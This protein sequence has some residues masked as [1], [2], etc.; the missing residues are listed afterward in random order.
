MRSLIR[1]F[2]FVPLAG[3]TFC[4]VGAELFNLPAVGIPPQTARAVLSV[5]PPVLLDPLLTIQ[6]IVISELAALVLGQLAA[7]FGTVLAVA[8]LW[9]AEDSSWLMQ[10]PS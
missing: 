6:S 3:L 5:V 1:Y 8:F 9:T 4:I 2:E 7:L 10:S